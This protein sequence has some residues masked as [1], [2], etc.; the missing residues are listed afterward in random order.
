MMN[1]LSI[2]YPFL[3]WPLALVGQNRDT[4]IAGNFTDQRDHHVYKWVKIGNQTWMAE[5]LAFIPT[6]SPPK[7]GSAVSP[8]YYVQGFE[9]IGVGEAKVSSLYKTYGVLYNWVAA[10]KACPSGWH[11]PSDEEWKDME[12]YLGMSESE[13]DTLF[14]NQGTEGGMLKESGTSHWSGQNAGANNS[15]GFTALPGGGRRD[16]GGFHDF[17]SYAYFWSSTKIESSTFAIYRQ[18]SYYFANIFRNYYN[19]SSG[20]SV[21]CVQN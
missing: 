19:R 6:V 8:K 13:A 17:E 14:R 3:F 2:F 7:E 10:T 12:K 21:R 5:N 11:L 16:Y 20:Y 18:L 4:L 1:R 15:T 9:G